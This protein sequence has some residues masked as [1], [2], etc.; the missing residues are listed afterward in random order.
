MSQAQTWLMA[1]CFALLVSTAYTCFA[2]VFRRMGPPAV[3]IDYCVSLALQP[4]FIAGLACSFSSTFVRM[5]LFKVAGVSRTVLLSEL[6][7]VISL[8]MSVAIFRER[9]SLREVAGALLILT[10][11]LLVGR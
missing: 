1:F 8:A 6:S 4:L 9:L 3:S 7:V 2:L 10:G 11:L 5:A